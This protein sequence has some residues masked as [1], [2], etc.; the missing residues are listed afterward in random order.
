M[1]LKNNCDARRWKQPFAIYTKKGRG[2]N[3]SIGDLEIR[4]QG[5]R[6]RVYGPSGVSA[7]P[8]LGQ[9]LVCPWTNHGGRKNGPSFAIAPQLRFSFPGRHPR[10]EGGTSGRFLGGVAATGMAQ[11]QPGF[12]LYLVLP[13][14]RRRVFALFGRQKLLEENFRGNTAQVFDGLLDDADRGPE[15]GGQ[16]EIVKTKKGD[17]FGNGHSQLLKCLKGIDGRAVLQR[18]DGLGR[19]RCGKVALDGIFG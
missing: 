11:H 15:G 2:G 10:E 17:A 3:D 4:V 1:Q 5:A 19:L 18:K 6:S 8:K 12:E 7:Q 16:L 13:L 9:P 14:F